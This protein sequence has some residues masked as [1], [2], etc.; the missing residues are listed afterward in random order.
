MPVIS[1]ASLAFTVQIGS[2]LAL[3]GLIWFVQMVHYPLFLRMDPSTFAAFESEHATRTGYVAAPLM[4]AELLSAGLLLDGRWRPAFLSVGQAW[5]GAAL[6][7]LLWASTF[8][9][10]VP[11]HN[12]LHRGFDR[13]AVRRLIGTNWIRTLLWTTRA[14]LV[15]FWVA[16]LLR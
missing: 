7:V 4:L 16:R 10:Q 11:L 14:G 3:F 1:L 12:S 2:T 6:V 8:L 9:L 15:L 13:N 5:G